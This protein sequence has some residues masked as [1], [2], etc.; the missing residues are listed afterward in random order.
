MSKPRVVTSTCAIVIALCASTALASDGHYCV[1]PNYFAY[2]LRQPDN[3]QAHDVFVVALPRSGR[4]PVPFDLRIAPT[5]VQW[6]RC[7]PD[8]VQLMTDRQLTVRLDPALRD[9]RLI[10]GSFEAHDTPVGPFPTL[11]RYSVVARQPGFHR[12]PLEGVT[13]PGY[14]LEIAGRSLGVPLDPRAEICELAI[15]SRLVRLDAEGR[16]SDAREVFRGRGYRECTERPRVA[17]PCRAE[18]GR[19]AESMSGT[20]T[21]N[22]LVLGSGRFRVHLRSFNGETYTIKVHE[23]DRDDDLAQLTPP[24]HGPNYVSIDAESF[25]NEDN[26]GPFDAHF[27]GPL[28]YREFIFS[29]EIGRSIDLHT[30][31]QSRDLSAIVDNVGKYGRGTLDILEY[32]LTPPKYGER[33]VFLSMKVA[34]CLTWPEK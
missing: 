16:E 25:R 5:D 4:I 17:S 27:E 14:F 28:W 26:T 18:L 33:P 21:G 31:F 3:Y 7:L 30:V 9:G 6:M 20:V 1:G 22:D 19:V 11:G 34:A 29:P 32:T 10:S 12:L 8:A 2:E 13:A 23:R 15:V 24:F